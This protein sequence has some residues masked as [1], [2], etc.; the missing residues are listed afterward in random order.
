[1]KR[2]FDLVSASYGLS[3]VQFSIS[4]CETVFAV[5]AAACVLFATHF[6]Q[7]EMRTEKRTVF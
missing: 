4:K 3:V 6:S 5:R 1:M 7:P 2:Q